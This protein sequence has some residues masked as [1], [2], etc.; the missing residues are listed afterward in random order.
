MIDGKRHYSDVGFGMYNAPV[1]S[2][3]IDEYGEQHINGTIYTVEDRPYSNK[4]I[5]R[6]TDEGMAELFGFSLEPFNV[7]DFVTCNMVAQM[8]SLR[9]KRIAFLHTPDGSISIDGDVL[10]KRENGNIIETFLHEPED[11]FRVLIEEFGMILTR[12]LLRKN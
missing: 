5:M 3:N 6:Q 10:R 1:A 11:S 8:L 4:I 7:I 2:I 9:S 12:P